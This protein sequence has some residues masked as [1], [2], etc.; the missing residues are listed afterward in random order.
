MD[1]ENTF[2]PRKVVPGVQETQ[3]ATPT[4]AGDAPAQPTTQPMSMAEVHAMQQQA[5]VTIP[6]VESEVAV[7][8]NIPAEFRQFMTNQNQ[9]KRGPQSRPT[10]TTMHSNAPT[11]GGNSDIVKELL[12]ETKKLTEN[13]DQIVLP[14]MGRFYDGQDGPS[15]GKL[16]IR[17]M[18]GNEEKILATPRFVKKGQAVNMIFK[19]CIA[20][21]FDPEEFLTIDRTYML[22]FLRGISYTPDYEVEIKCTECANKFQ[23]TINLDTL[24]CD[25]CPEEFNEDAL[26]DTLPSTGFRFKYR[27]S[28]G[29]DETLI[30]EHRDRRIK[31]YGDSAHDD[32]LLYRASLLV[33]W[34]ESPSGEMLTGVGSIQTVIE[35]LPI[36]DVAYIRNLL[37]D[38]PFGVDTK[39]TLVCPLCN[40]DF[41]A[42]LPL[43]ANFFFP[44]T[45]AKKV[46]RV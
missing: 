6:T 41:S 3:S 45:K 18:T 31:T 39:V 33:E 8:G 7:Q 35:Q 22:I 38:P 21:K 12:A 25:Y 42:D 40:N 29:R 23:T 26:V 36:K 9:P 28:K 10:N 5:G 1:K 32:T 16:H 37:T 20:E 11:G 27:L 14:S 17:P 2:R 24:W 43:E 13:F 19:N 44:R 46:T 34:I 30:Q 15:D 4:E